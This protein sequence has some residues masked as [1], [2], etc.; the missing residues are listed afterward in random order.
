MINRET[1]STQR[2]QELGQD[3][4]SSMLCM[5]TVPM[6]LS[7]ILILIDGHNITI[8]SQT[9]AYSWGVSFLSPIVFKKAV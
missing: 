5:Y 6:L 7:G 3:F 8:E 4:I 2:F 1:I 9:T